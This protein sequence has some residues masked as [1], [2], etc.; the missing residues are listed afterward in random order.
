VVIVSSLDSEGDIRGEWLW[1][2]H[3]LR[4]PII[5]DSGTGPE[6][7][8]VSDFVDHLFSFSKKLNSGL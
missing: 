8:A 3:V 5:L 6:E 2:V 4:E 1:H 7:R